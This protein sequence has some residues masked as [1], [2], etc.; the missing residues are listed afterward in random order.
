LREWELTS[1][2]SEIDYARKLRLPIKTSKEKIYS[3]DKNIWGVSIE[4]GILED[5][6]NSP[7]E[8]A[9]LLTQSL[10]NTPD[11]PESIKVGFSQGRP[12]SLNGK[13]M[14]FLAIIE[15]LNLIGGRHCIGR[16]DCL[17][18]RTVGIKSRE[19]YEA[20]AAWIL[21]TAHKELEKVV[22]D[23]DTLNFK[24]IVALHYSQMV[25]QGL[26]FSS[27]KESLDAFIDK[28]Q[29]K[30]DGEISLKLFKGNIILAGRSSANSLYKKELATYGTGDTFDRTDA[31]GFINIT[32][33]PYIRV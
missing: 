32:A 30:V 31:K 15:E 23:R 6:M 27:L 1:R 21:I 9:F 22:L 12:V 8:N 28:T 18:N 10:E 16:T 5:L 33:M 4:A 3:I 11:K 17:E 7:E 29:R 24:E 13:K 20:P 14:D 19:I 25:Y 2:E 26:W